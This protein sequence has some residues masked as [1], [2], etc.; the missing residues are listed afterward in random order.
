MVNNYIKSPEQWLIFLSDLD[1]MINKE[2]L[3]EICNQ[4]YYSVQIHK[5]LKRKVFQDMMLNKSLKYINSQIA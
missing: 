3:N 2:L 4:I 5:D 1:T